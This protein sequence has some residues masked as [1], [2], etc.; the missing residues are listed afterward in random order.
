MSEQIIV[1]MTSYGKR[2]SNI[3]DVFNTIFSQTVKPNLVVLNLAFGETI[4]KS[5]MDYLVLHRVEINYVPDTKVYKKIIP[6][7][8]K[9]P[10]ACV[11]CID[12]DFLYPKHMIADF[13][14]MHEHYPNHPISGNRVVFMG[15]QCHC[16]CASLIKACFLG[17]YLAQID[18]DIISNCPSD[19]MLFTFFSNKN[20][21]PYLRTKE[22]YFINLEGCNC[23]DDEGYSISIGGESG[24]FKTYEY[25][26]DRYGPV[27]ISF[28]H[29]I[30]DKHISVVLN[31]IHDDL[32]ARAEEK[33]RSTRS[34]RLGKA[35]L[36]PFKLLKK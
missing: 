14:W 19:D 16:G 12:D 18:D 11:I 9:Y 23:D 25:L 24:I 3:P 28:E 5:V 10:E 33:I 36:A 8:K 15:M 4:P 17:D 1:S 20:G 13:I 35:L 29:Y 31:N 2:L 32:L 34:Y 27:T 22:E 7:L 6:T 30:S 26:L 21:H